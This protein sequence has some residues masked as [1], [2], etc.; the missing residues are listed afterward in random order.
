MQQSS[1][2]PGELYEGYSSNI[3]ISQ[4]IT[5]CTLRVVP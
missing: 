1:L 5:L 3:D 2:A 4:N